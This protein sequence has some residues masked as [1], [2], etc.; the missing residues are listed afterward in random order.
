M[1]YMQLER[2]Y[3]GMITKRL[4]CVHLRHPRR[5]RVS[6]NR[7]CMSSGGRERR[8]VDPPADNSLRNDTNPRGVPA[9]AELFTTGGV[10]FRP[11]SDLDSAWGPGGHTRQIVDHESRPR[12]GLQI[13]PF[14]RAAQAVT[15]YLDRLPLGV[16]AKAHRDD[17]GRA[18]APDRC[19]AAQPLSPQVLDLL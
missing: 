5:G 12:V 17:V 15:S 14:L 16:E 3:L 9:R 8:P 2:W 11:P 18:I 4:R 1:R 7:T 6:R 13:A 10:Q 19:E